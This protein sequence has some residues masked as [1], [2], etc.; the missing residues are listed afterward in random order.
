M[1]DMKIQQKEKTPPPKKKE[2]KRNETKPT[3]TRK[4]TLPH[5][6][7]LIFFCMLAFLTLGIGEWVSG[8]GKANPTIHS[9]EGIQL[10]ILYT[11]L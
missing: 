1:D 4:V 10:F 3:P 7:I 5:I 2:K 6:S 11:F 9:C 8:V